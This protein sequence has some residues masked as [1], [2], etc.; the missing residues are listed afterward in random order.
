MNPVSAHAEAEAESFGHLAREVNEQRISNPY[1]LHLQSSPT[2][3]ALAEAWWRGWDAAH[4]VLKD[5]PA[6]GQDGAL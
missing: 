1:L 6:V 5:V 3:Q 4:L 2:T